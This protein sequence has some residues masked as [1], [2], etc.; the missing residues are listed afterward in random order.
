MALQ[1]FRLPKLIIRWLM[2]RNNV[3]ENSYR[4]W[5]IL[6]GCLRP[7][8]LK[9]LRLNIWSPIHVFLFLSILSNVL[10]LSNAACCF[11]KVWLQFV[12]FFFNLF[13]LSGC[14]KYFLSFLKSSTFTTI[15]PDE[16][17]LQ[18]LSR[19]AEGED[20]EYTEGGWR[21][22][23]EGRG[24][25]EPCM[26]LPSTRACLQPSVAPGEGRSWI[27]DEWPTLITDLW[28]PGWRR[29]HDPI[30]IWADRESCL[31]KW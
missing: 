14:P 9:C 2:N 30:D 4:R 6:K 18:T 20:W 11:E 17:D 3:V 12:L 7:L 19:S 31:E 24:I 10:L 23:A 16:E 29:P 1:S 26:G 5:H 27:G 8:C 21:H 28:N 22:W 25:W 15:Y 13:F